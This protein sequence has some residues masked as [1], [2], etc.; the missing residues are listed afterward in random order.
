ML[1]QLQPDEL[2]P[3]VRGSLDDMHQRLGSDLVAPVFAYPA[4]GHDPR[5]RDAVRRAGYEAAFTTE[6]GLVDIR[7]SDR[8]RLPRL[9]VGR[10]SSLGVVAAE[11]AVRRLRRPT[12]DAA[13]ERLG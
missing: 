13:R 8:F 12:R 11:A 1:D 6:R 4:G 9:N 3:E 10:G 5:V 2:D 7:H